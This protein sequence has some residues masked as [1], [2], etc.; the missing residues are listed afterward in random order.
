VVSSDE[1][2]NVSGN[3]NTQHGIWT[4]SGARQP[5]FPF[6][7]KPNINVDLEDPSEPLEQSEF[8]YTR[9]CGS[10]S[11]RNKLVCPTNFKKHA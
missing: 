1:E 7:G 8:L 2:E 9:Y 10:N 3:S 5:H 4:K 11:Q 6:T